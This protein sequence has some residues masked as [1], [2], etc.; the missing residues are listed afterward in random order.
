MTR[1]DDWHVHLRDGLAL[2]DT[3]RDTSRYMRRAIIMPNIIPPVTTTSLANAYKKR[4]L[5]ASTDKKFQPLMTLYLTDNTT[6]GEIKKAK[7]SGFVYAAKLYP[8]GATTN[9]NAGVTSTMNIS[10][11]LQAMQDVGMPLLVHGE[12]TD[13]DIDIFDREAMFLKTVLRP[14]VM[15]YPQLK[16]VLEHITTRQ[17]VEF[18]EQA[19][20][21]IAATITAHH[22]LFNRNHMLLN[23]IKPHFYCLPILKRKDHQ[24]ALINA[25]TSG[26][27]KFFLGTDSAP[28]TR[29][30][31]E[32]NCGCAGS[33]TAFA[34]IEL[35][36]EVF[37]QQNALDKLEAF[38]SF[39]GP[40]FYN[41][42][43]N[44]DTIELNKEFWTVPHSMKFGDDRLV[45]I[46][47]GET[48]RWKVI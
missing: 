17:A 30:N 35:Y 24:K 48:I 3:V 18:V 23:G 34:A 6:A 26:S 37:D 22:L 46:K 43:R 27:S 8:A 42:S 39:N 12:V 25:A 15:Q 13:H 2:V 31:K 14:L 47:A 45:P 21:N 32:S 28:H 5:K 44:L 1:P 36:A 10:N 20:N 16:I 40:D 9:S 41:L 4:I 38:A 29:K 7:D 19:G 11:A 33:Y